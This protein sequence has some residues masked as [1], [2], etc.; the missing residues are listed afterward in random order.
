MTKRMKKEKAAAV[1]KAEKKN[2][3]ENGKGQPIAKT[4]K[5]NT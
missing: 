3:K 5:L 1:K 2:N 4:A